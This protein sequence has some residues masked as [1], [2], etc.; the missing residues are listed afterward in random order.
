M[1]YLKSDIILLDFYNIIKKAE[2]SIINQLFDYG[3]TK[4]INLHNQDTKKII[5]HNVIYQICEQIIK[6]DPLKKKVII[7]TEAKLRDTELAKYCE[8]KEY[9]KFFKTLI[10]KL[11]TILPIPVCRSMYDAENT[12]NN[13][14]ES[15]EI[16]ACAQ[17]AI[18]YMQNQSF[19]FQ[20]I[21][22]FAQ[23]HGLIFLSSNY[24][25]DLKIKQLLHF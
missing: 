12:K 17:E 21:K 10:T 20:K 14:G 6:A 1:S 18:K 9:I 3:L 16:Q 19:S 13:T 2:T 23:K 22:K 24:F 11:Q 7:V 15:R 8:L 25:N 4:K 5:Y